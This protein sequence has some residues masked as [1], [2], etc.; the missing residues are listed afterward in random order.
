MRKVILLGILLLLA[1]TALSTGK[2]V[3]SRSDDGFPAFWIRF[4]TA[5]IA[6]DKKAVAE[7]SKFPIGVAEGV[8]D[9]HASAELNRRFDDLFNKQTNAAQC[10]ATKEPTKDTESQNRFTVVCPNKLDNFVVYEFEN[11]KHGW[12]FIHRQFP[13][14][15]RCRGGD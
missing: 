4:K 1:G 13:T 15:C 7:L 12:R 14:K 9:I 8:P 11:T 5:V 10:F 3:G 2:R 6:G